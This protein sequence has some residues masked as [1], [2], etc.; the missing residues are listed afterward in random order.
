MTHWDTTQKND[1]T[2]N[3]KSN[4][5]SLLFSHNKSCFASNNPLE[6]KDRIKTHMDSYLLRKQWLIK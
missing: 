4:R 1:V 6:Y 3:K 2:K 5:E